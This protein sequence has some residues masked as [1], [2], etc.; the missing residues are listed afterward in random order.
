MTNPGQKTMKKKKRRTPS[1]SKEYYVREK[2]GKRSCAVCKKPM[3]GVPHGKTVAEVSKLSKTKKRPSVPF[4]G[5]LCTK[6]RRQ[7]FEEKAKV[8]NGL[9]K[10]EDVDLLINNY[11]GIKE[12]SK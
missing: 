5:V 1:G 9:K 8:E 3:H 7:V 2:T 4:G 12:A 6:C 11:I 10:A